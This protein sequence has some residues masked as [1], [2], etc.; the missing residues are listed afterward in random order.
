MSKTLA[1]YMRLSSE[2]ENSGESD[3]ITNQRDLLH[4]F[5]ADK[6]E[7]KSCEVLEF[8]DDG[9][10]GTNFNR[11]QIK[12]LLLMAR[13]K[14]IDCV[15][16]KDFSRFGRNYIDVCD[17]LEQ[18]FPLYG[19]RFVA[20]ND[21]YD[22]SLA[23][24]S[25]VGM[26]VALKS[27][28]CELYSRDISTKIRSANKV[29]WA[30]GEYLGTIAFYGYKLSE[31]KKNKLVIDEAAAQVVRRIFQMAVDGI[32]PN[33][34][35]VILN[36]EQVLTP[37]A[38][39]EKNGTHHG[40]GWTA[41]NDRR[42]WTRFSVKHLLCDERYTGMLISYKQTKADVTSKRV[43]MNDKSEW[44]VAE[45][46]HEAIVTQEIFEKAGIWFPKKVARQPLRS[47]NHLFTGILKCGYC[48]HTLTRASV[49]QPYY[50]CYMRK[51]EK[52]SLCNHVKT[53]EESLC[54]LVLEI[55][56]KQV[57]LVILDGR[58][59]S[60]FTM[61]NHQKLCSLQDRITV[62]KNELEKIR[63]SRKQAFEEY[64]FE[65]ITKEKYMMLLDTFA[66]QAA[67]VSA[68]LQNLQTE[69]SGIAE[70]KQEIEYQQIHK[71]YAFADE[72]TRDMVQAFIRE[73]RVFEDE[74]FEITWNYAD[75]YRLSGIL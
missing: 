15:I 17:Y 48:N 2:D 64:C 53:L 55:I 57:E 61:T 59:P 45:N 25:S 20:V 73:I 40:R 62:K 33:E 71:K 50:F 12:R 35:A 28:I 38:Y 18:V 31:T 14:R 63:L 58:N 43:K 13:Q 6:L 72:L 4:S 11:P 10:S 39:R 36:E 37:L 9:Y 7:F 68:E 23:K 56:N 16:V 51:Y 66:N 27:M 52:E 65:Q 5:I 44:I 32:N 75:Y 67:A 60:D 22:S 49:K 3:S 47:R 41:V 42:L 8:C 70:S 69:C 30:K 29:R 54:R 74:R 21:N 1:L 46:A 24:G 26:D 34:I 19:V